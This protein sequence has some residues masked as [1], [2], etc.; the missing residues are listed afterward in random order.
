MTIGAI[1]GFIGLMAVLMVKPFDF[2]EAE[3]EIYWGMFTELGG[4]RLAM[5]FFLK[6][7]EKIV[8]PIIYVLLFL[9]GTWPFTDNWLLG[10]I[11]I[12]IKYFIVLT[13]LSILENSLPRYRPDQGIVFLWKYGY[14]LA[15]LSLIISIYI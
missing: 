10:V 13:I 11:I 12:F 9:G 8:F 5:G 6:F 1:A 7:V 15:I 4:P 3:S 14:P 2:P